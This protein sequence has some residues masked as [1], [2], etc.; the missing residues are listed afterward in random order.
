[1]ENR[2]NYIQFEQMITKLFNYKSLII[3]D[4]QAL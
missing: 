4:Y 2:L 3:I 1:M